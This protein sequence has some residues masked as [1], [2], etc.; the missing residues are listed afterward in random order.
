MKPEIKNIFYP[1][2]V[3]IAGASSKERSIGY[4]LLKCIKNYGFKGCI[5]PVNPNCNEILGF[6][7]YSSVLEIPSEID[8][9]IIVVPKKFIEATIDQF[10]EKKVGALIII[11]AGFKEIGNEGRKLEFEIKD[12]LSKNKISFVGPNCM[13]VI[14]SAEEVRLNATFVAEKPEFGKIAFLSQ[15]GALGAAVLN[16]LRQTNIRFA[17]FISVGNKADLIENDFLEFWEEDE[18]VKV[19]TMYLESFE[20]GFEFLKLFIENKITKPVILLKAGRSESGIK[21]A[22]SH[23]GAMSSN[24]EV[25]D[26]LMKQ[27]GI[28]RVD[29]INELFNTAKGFEYFPMPKGN[30]VAVVTNAGGPA[31]LAVDKIENEGLN[32]AKLSEPT[33]AKLKLI[34]HP[35]GS[36]NNPIDLLPGGNAEIYKNVIEILLSDE[37]VDSII[38]IFVEPV[39]VKPIPVIQSINSIKSEKPIFQVVF[40]L[41]EFWNEYKKVSSQPLFKNSE[42]PAEVISN[43]VFYNSKAGNSKNGYVDLINI[44]AKKISG[45]SNSFLSNETVNELLNE[46]NIPQPLQT[47]VNNKEKLQNLSNGFFPCVVKGINAHAIHKTELKA[48]KLN[49][50]NH[51]EL[52]KAASNIEKSMNEKGFAPEKFLVQKLIRAKHEILLGG[53]RDNSFGPITTF[54]TGGTFVE[55]INDKSIRSAF[56]TKEDIVCMINETKLGKILSGVRGEKSVDINKLVEIILSFNRMLIENSNISEVDINPLILSAENNFYA[57]D[58]RIKIN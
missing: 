50:S 8:L 38:S 1:K 34:V 47:L 2:S 55:I 15:S 40:P 52:M 5:L 41:P 49:L 53:F 42:E 51:N 10:I 35:E 18:L 13:G 57:I 43:M 58:T 54:G 3:C 24:D 30:K 29:T 21:A 17:H 37:N 28:I 44:P 27:F 31:I 6:K 11:T 12:K 46:Y 45:N 25:I 36:V 39:M 33:K 32:L 23:T 4:E 26:S 22:S 14:N 19:I 20:N 7:T 48:V 9:G 16:S 56:S